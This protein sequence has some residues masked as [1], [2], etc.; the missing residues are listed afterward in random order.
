MWADLEPRKAG[1]AL[2]ASGSRKILPPGEQGKCLEPGENCSLATGQPPLSSAEWRKVESGSVLAN[3]EHLTRCS[4]L[5]TRQLRLS[6]PHAVQQVGPECTDMCACVHVHVHACVCVCVCMRVGV[7]REE[8][9]APFWKHQRAGGAD[10]HTHP[11]FLI[12]Y[13]V[14]II[15][16]H[17]TSSIKVS[18]ESQESNYPSRNIF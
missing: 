8:H 15:P 17:I 7:K 18:W 13:K 4:I 12:C 5:Q 11:R 10:T 6:C 3:G 9:R 2:G 16:T 1:E 14:S